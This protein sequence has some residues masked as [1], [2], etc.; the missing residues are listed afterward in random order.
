MDVI[1]GPYVLTNPYK[2]FKGGKSASKSQ[3]R[4]RS[5]SNSGAAKHSNATGGSGLRATTVRVVE[6]VL[7]GRSLDVAFAEH[8]GRLNDRDQ[9]WVRATSNGVLRDWRLLN[10]LLQCCLSRPGQKTQESIVIL[11]A[12]GIYQLRSMRIPGHAAVSAT[13]DASAP[14][15]MSK[16]RGFVNA[17][18]RRFLREQEALESRLQQESAAIRHSHPDWLVEQLRKDWG[19]Q[20]DAVLEANQTRAPMVL[21]ADEAQT[22]VVKVCEDLETA[23][24]EA[25]VH[26]KVSTALVLES[27]VAVSRLPG[28]AAGVISVQDAGAQLA[29]RILNP[30]TGFRVLDACAAPG[31][32]TIHLA[33]LQPKAK[34]VALDVDEQRLK[35]VKENLLRTNC[36]NVQVRQADAAA[37]DAWWDGQHFDQILLDAPCSGTGVIRRH[38]DI[39][40]LRRASDIEPMVQRQRQ[41][42]NALWPTLKKGGE[43]LYVTC[44]VL[45]AENEHLIA[46]FL[47]D[48]ADAN[49]VATDVGL[50]ETLQHGRR[51]MPGNA[52][53]GFYYAL[54]KKA[55]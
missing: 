11:C 21:R 13:V 10:F 18:L 6:S 46:E 14:L 23:G 15:R 37:P 7:A 25:G 26:S 20:T 53:D 34:V 24:I 35:R 29:A 16:A 28:F 55:P 17:I 41:M 2:N 38:P 5:E 44:S 40:W 43:L 52:S 36:L 4:S 30:Q 50:G 1:L 33:Q 51:I 19:D 54:L 39:K 22:S 42:L 9:A 45:S 31:G 12:V 32:K 47:A 48:T 3:H 8:L 49:A 27:P